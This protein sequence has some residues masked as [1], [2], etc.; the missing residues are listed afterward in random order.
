MKSVMLCSRLFHNYVHVYSIVMSQERRKF[1]PLGWNIP[2]EFN[3]S[4]WYASV[5]FVQNHL[6]DMDV[7]KVLTIIFVI[8][9]S[10]IFRVMLTVDSRMPLYEVNLLWSIVFET[11]NVSTH[12]LGILVNYWC[13]VRQGYHLLAI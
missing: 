10:T 8:Y 9:A 6:D 12:H 11:C 7:K 3:S 13:H 1:G 5:Q 2:Y 4:D